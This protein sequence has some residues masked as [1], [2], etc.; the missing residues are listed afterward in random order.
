MVPPNCL[1]PI[2][3]NVTVHPLSIS[4]RMRFVKK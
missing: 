2:I 3:F 1:L 4:F